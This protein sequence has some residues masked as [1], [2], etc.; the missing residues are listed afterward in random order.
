MKKYRK[1]SLQDEIDKEAERIEK[2]ILENPDLEDIQVSEGFDAAFLKKVQEYEKKKAEREKK[3]T[4][5]TED[6]EFA[7]ELMPDVDKLPFDRNNEKDSSKDK[8]EVT[9]TVTVYRRRK[10][11]YL[12]VALAAVLI[13]VLGSGLT[14]VGSKSYWKVLWERIV[15]DEKAAVINVEDMEVQKTEDNKEIDAFKDI[16]KQLGI[17]AVRFQYK[18]QN[19]ILESY[20]I[21]IEQKR[22]QL[23]YNY[24]NRI[25][26]YT[27]Y[28]NDT[29]SSLSQKELDKQTDV[30]IVENGNEK[31]QVEEYQKDSEYRY[32]ANFENRG[33]YYQLKGVMEREEFENIIKNL[34]FL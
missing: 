27:I 8:K 18:P 1:L 6:T 2:R 12:F 19:M 15:G 30:F 31:I 21:D 24:N 33:I 23:F 34:K 25:I 13:L 20:S 9:G 5:P 7:E 29:D 17:S 4:H 11:S 10:R 28:L 26:R 22:A 3:K 32:I 14:S 16:G